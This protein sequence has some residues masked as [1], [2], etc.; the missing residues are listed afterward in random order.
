M[1]TGLGLVANAGNVA[2]LSSPV[3]FC[4]KAWMELSPVPT[5][6]TNASVGA[7]LLFFDPRQPVERRVINNVAIEMNAFIRCFL[8]L[9]KIGVI[10]RY[11]R[12]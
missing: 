5:M 6:Y 8:I 7:V 9:L 4:V 12:P 10:T 1:A 3:D 11:G 2:K